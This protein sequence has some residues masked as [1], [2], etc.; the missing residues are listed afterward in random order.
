MLNIWAKLKFPD[1]TELTCQLKK[2]ELHISLTHFQKDYGYAAYFRVLENNKAKV[3]FVIGKSRLAPLIKKRL[4]I[5]KL[6]L[7]ATVPAARIKIR[8][9]E[10]TNFNVKRIYFWSDSETYWNAYTRRKNIF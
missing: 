7:Q 2:P 4:S 8:L 3:W 9:F 1:T 10:E 6:E 5:R